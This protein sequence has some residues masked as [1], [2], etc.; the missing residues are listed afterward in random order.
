MDIPKILMMFRDPASP[1][2]L[3]TPWLL[4]GELQICPRLHFYAYN[5]KFLPG[6]TTE[7]QIKLIQLPTAHFYQNIPVTSQ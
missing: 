7:F 6:L 5:P 2:E 4:P 3:L 1:P